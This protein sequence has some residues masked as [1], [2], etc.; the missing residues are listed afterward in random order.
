[1]TDKMKFTSNAQ[2]PKNICPGM[3]GNDITTDNHSTK[4]AAERV[5]KALEYG[6]FGGDGEVFPLKTWVE[7]KQPSPITLRH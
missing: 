3:Y 4:E 2:W 5:C 6:G 7:E 1:M